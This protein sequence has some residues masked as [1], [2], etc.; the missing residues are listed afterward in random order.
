MHCKSWTKIFLFRFLVFT[1][2]NFWRLYEFSLSRKRNSAVARLHAYFHTHLV[3]PLNTHNVRIYIIIIQATFNRYDF[4]TFNQTI[5]NTGPKTIH[6]YFSA[7][8]MSWPIFCIFSIQELEPS[9][10][11]RFLAVLRQLI[12]FKSWSVCLLGTI[13]NSP[14]IESDLGS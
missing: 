11:H 10:P 9:G 7:E 4:M 13:S 12:R 14:A 6:K 1:Y 3:I 5:D 8:K 2:V